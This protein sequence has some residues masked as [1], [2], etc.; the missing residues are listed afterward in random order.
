VVWGASL[1]VLDDDHIGQCLG[2]TGIYDLAVSEG[3]FSAR[4]PA[5]CATASS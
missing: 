4:D 3:L 5:C 2:T 1:L